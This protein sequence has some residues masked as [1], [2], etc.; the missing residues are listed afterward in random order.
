VKGSAHNVAGDVK[1]A[2]AML[3]KQ[4]DSPRPRLAALRGGFFARGTPIKKSLG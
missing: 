4:R 1:D 3:Q 2:A